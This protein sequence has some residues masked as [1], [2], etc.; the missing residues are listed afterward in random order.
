MK[1][2]FLKTL[3]V[4]TLLVWTG[5]SQACSLWEP[6][7]CLKELVQPSS[8]ASQAQPP[9]TAATPVAAAEAQPKV[10]AQPAAPA[11]TINSAAAATGNNVAAVA[12]APAAPA[13]TA[14]RFFGLFGCDNQA[15]TAEQNNGQPCPFFGLFGCNNS[16]TQAEESECNGP[17]PF[18]TCKA[19]LERKQQLAQD[20]ARYQQR[21]TV[22]LARR[23]GLHP[24]AWYAGTPEAACKEAQFDAYTEAGQ[25]CISDVSRRY[26]ELKEKLRSG[27]EKIGSCREWA[28]SKGSR[29]EA[30]Q[31][32]M[33]LDSMAEIVTPVVFRGEVE[34]GKNGTLT[35]RH[36][37]DNA[38]V[39]VNANT[40]VIHKSSL[41]VG[42]E[43]HGYGLQTGRQIVA[44]INGQSTRVPVI[45]AACL[46]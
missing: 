11:K 20:E 35:I 42:Q 37:A 33:R 12:A 44:Q 23:T 22:A 38:C 4:L 7:T 14:C 46:E 8:T 31:T 24:G 39:S 43:L 41:M 45:E 1:P 32:D 34:E 10:A 15:K 17:D 25:R 30:A 19:R 16:A 9:A 26:A 27:A 21:L 13:A 29:W 28:I 3:M 40:V 2:L 36:A 18:G 6:L 5:S